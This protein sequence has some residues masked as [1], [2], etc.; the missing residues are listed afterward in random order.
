MMDSSLFYLVLST[1]NFLVFLMFYLLHS[2]I[3]RF[4]YL[5]ISFVW[6]LALVISALAYEQELWLKKHGG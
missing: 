5:G 2:D 6:L 1:V 4:G 3:I